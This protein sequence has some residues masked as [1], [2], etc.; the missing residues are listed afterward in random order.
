MIS[1]RDSV[2]DFLEQSEQKD[3]A[4]SIVQI[5]APLMQVLAPP[6]L[7]NWDIPPAGQAAFEQLA[8]CDAMP[9]SASGQYYA[10]SARSFSLAYNSFLNLINAQA[11]PLPRALNQSINNNIPPGNAAKGWVQ[12]MNLAGQLEW[13]RMWNVSQ[14]PAAWLAGFAQGQQKNAAEWIFNDPQLSISIGNSE[15]LPIVP[16]TQVKLSAE[17]VGR[18]E[19]NPGIWYD[20]SIVTLAQSNKYYLKVSPTVVFGNAGL[21]NCRI[22]EF[23]VALKPSP[24]II[25]DKAL[26]SQNT[27]TGISTAGFSF[28]DKIT[29]PINNTSVVKHVDFSL[30]D[31]GEGQVQVSGTINGA[32][33]DNVFIVA[34]ILECYSM[35]SQNCI[36]Q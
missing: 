1:F 6:L 8:F 36:T 3:V 25:I 9:Q 35:T 12:S 10:A 13:K 21:M 30:S 19:V 24:S 34:V 5:N 31:V 29:A 20:S 26:I 15:V 4:R 33:K 18:I 22:A 27:V 32:D 23:I 16:T 7:W 14:N 17:A 28:A 11:F 2:V